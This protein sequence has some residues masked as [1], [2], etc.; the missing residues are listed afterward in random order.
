[1]WVV[2][3]GVERDVSLSFAMTRAARDAAD[4][5]AAA[6][7]GYCVVDGAAPQRVV[8]GSVTRA[9]DATP[10]SVR[11]GNHA[12]AVTDVVGTLTLPGPELPGGVTYRDEQTLFAGESATLGPVAGLYEDGMLVSF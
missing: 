2:V 1:M 9:L 5:P 7:L 10:V 8:D 11:A 3:A 4:A 6:R 12:V